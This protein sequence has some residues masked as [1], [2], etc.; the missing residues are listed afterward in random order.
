ML[1]K[2][3][4][5]KLRVPNL[6]CALLLYVLASV[7]CLGAHKNDHACAP[8]ISSNSPKKKKK[9]NEPVHLYLHKSIMQA[10]HLTISP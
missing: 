7:E 3:K 5:R 2:Q 8:A 9:S 10:K 4:R 1:K 6:L